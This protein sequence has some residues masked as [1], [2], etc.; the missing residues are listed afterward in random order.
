MDFI[1]NL[2]LLS[3]NRLITFEEIQDHIGKLVF[4]LWKP[5]NY[6]YRAELKRVIVPPPKAPKPSKRN[7]SK[8]VCFNFNKVVKIGLQNL[9][10]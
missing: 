10:C 9:Q 3:E 1:F 2:E 7:K 8:G 6:Y 4:I 5:D